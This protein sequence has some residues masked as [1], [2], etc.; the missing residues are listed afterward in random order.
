MLG[1]VYL[2]IPTTMPALIISKLCIAASHYTKVVLLQW[3]GGGG[4]RGRK[5]LL[6]WVI[7]SLYGPAKW[8]FSDFLWI[9]GGERHSLP[10]CIHSFISPSRLISSLADLPPP[11]PLLSPTPTQA[12]VIKQMISSLYND[13]QPS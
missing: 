1:P 5:E 12:H 13:G 10:A 3:D 9:E 6:V 4:G 2:S 11:L 8:P 7:R